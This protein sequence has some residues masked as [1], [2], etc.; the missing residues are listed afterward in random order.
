MV[1]QFRQ[2]ANAPESLPNTTTSEVPR[3]TLV[4]RNT[5][6]DLIQM[7]FNSRKHKQD[8]SEFDPPKQEE[9]LHTPLYP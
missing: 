6:T 4:K 5:G 2:E 3:L 9:N 8:A 1:S 7:Q